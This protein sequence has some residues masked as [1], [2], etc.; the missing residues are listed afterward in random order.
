MEA[1]AVSYPPRRLKRVG[2]AYGPISGSCMRPMPAFAN[3]RLIS[4]Q[5]APVPAPSGNPWWQGQGHHPGR[6]PPTRGLS[7]A[8][9]LIDEHP[10]VLHNDRIGFHGKH[11]GRC[12]D[13]A[14]AHIE[15]A[16]MKIAL[17]D[18][19]AQ[20]AFRERARPV[21]ARVIGDEE[22]PVDI[23]DGEHQAAD[24]H[25]QGATLLNINRAAEL[26]PT[27]LRGHGASA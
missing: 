15:L 14:R 27:W 21:G 23:E 18:I 24:F 16:A 19:L 25:L 11:A 17:D 13:L 5:A 10:T 6:R 1:P 4:C 7:K 3:R 26:E 8:I 20:I 9:W 12:Y 22:F 2:L